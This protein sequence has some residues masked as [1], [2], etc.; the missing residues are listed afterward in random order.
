METKSE[1]VL[2]SR[3]DQILT[4]VKIEYSGIKLEPVFDTADTVLSEYTNQSH[5][6]SKPE[7]SE[8]FRASNNN[9]NNQMDNDLS[10]TVV[11]CEKDAE[12]CDVDVVNTDDEVN[13]G[14][15]ASVEQ[16]LNA[17]DNDNIDEAVLELCR[18]I[19]LE[20]GEDTSVANNF[21]HDEDL[22]NAISIL[23]DAMM[24][25]TAPNM[26]AYTDHSDGDINRENSSGSKVDVSDSFTNSVQNTS[27]SM[28]DILKSRAR[29]Q[30]VWNAGNTVS[31][32]LNNGKDRF[33]SL[34]SKQNKCRKKNTTTDTKNNHSKSDVSKNS[35]SKCKISKVKTIK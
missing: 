25:E 11:K 22:T 34:K 31:D 23:H 20:N 3:G 2:H 32:K 33:V 6:E 1:S 35:K 24:A 18:E 12:N 5:Y 15:I 14:G 21:E 19:S 7:V 29:R 4:E 16:N 28:Y 26:K 13:H 10:Y 8:L 30:N 27:L 17:S 9:Y